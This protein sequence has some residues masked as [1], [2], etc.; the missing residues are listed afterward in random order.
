[1][2]DTPENPA[3]E[4]HQALYSN[5]IQ[6]QQIYAGGSPD[7]IT[8]MRRQSSP[9]GPPRVVIPPPAT[10]VRR[11]VNPEDLKPLELVTLSSPSSKPI[12]DTLKPISQPPESSESI[13]PPSFSSPQ[14]TQS[15]PSPPPSDVPSN[16]P[17]DDPSPT[18]NLPTESMPMGS[19]ASVAAAA[20]RAARSR[21]IWVNPNNTPA[22][23]LAPKSTDEAFQ[24]ARQRRASDSALLTMQKME[25][26]S[27]PAPASVSIP[28]PPSAANAPPPVTPINQPKSPVQQ[29]QYA[30]VAAPPE[31]ETPAPQIGSCELPKFGA[32]TSAPAE[33]QNQ[34][35]PPASPEDKPASQRRQSTP[36][37]QPQAF[38][39]A[40]AF[41][42]KLTGQDQ[43]PRRLTDD[44]S[45]STQVE[46]QKLEEKLGMRQRALTDNYK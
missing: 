15:D 26:Q 40:F 44:D 23:P 35:P 6:N 36:D 37:I 13:P 46:V 8:R 10:I 22:N 17:S 43:Q 38:K 19:A 39:N 20:N 14:P 11:E 34:P 5:N 28:P 42:S 2:T 12:D 16:P 21:V 24:I 41:F 4:Q 31:Q 30:Q 25:L 33:A 45:S 9:A 18:I 32:A 3:F 27:T 7:A 1:M 29:P